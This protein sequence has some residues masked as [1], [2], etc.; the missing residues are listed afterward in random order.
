[1][2]ER[3]ILFNT[4]MVQAILEGR[5]NQ[6]R[7]VIK[8]QPQ[9]HHWE[10]DPLGR[11]KHHLN[12]VEC[13]RGQFLSSW[14][15]LGD[16]IDSSEES[17]QQILCPYGV[18][19]DRLYVRETWFEDLDPSVGYSEYHY[20][21]DWDEAYSPRV[22]W[23]PSIHMPK[24][25][26]RIW[27]ETTDIRVERVRDITEADV[28]AEGLQVPVSDTGSVLWCLTGKYLPHDYMPE[29]IMREENKQK[30]T[31]EMVFKAHFASLWDSINEK[32]GYGWEANPWVWV[33]E[34][35]RITP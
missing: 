11:Y 17:N 14:H 29:G 15:S 12:L 18:P 13:Q 3:P 4:E 30:I 10:N 2:R 31:S 32:R 19:G 27:L 28:K 5:K 16:H 6:T 33:V 22:P 21:A 9:D 34:F 1:M 23:K 26:A 35:K 7:R 8:P 24:D 25:A 20:R